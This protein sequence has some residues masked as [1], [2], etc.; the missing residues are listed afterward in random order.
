MRDICSEALHHVALIIASE[1][2]DDIKG[3]NE[4]NNAAR[5]L[6]WCAGKRDIILITESYRS[7]A[8]T[9]II[10]INDYVYKR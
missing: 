9:K 4:L 6:G 2:T 8:N 7:C 5:Y 3:R 1:A 10:I